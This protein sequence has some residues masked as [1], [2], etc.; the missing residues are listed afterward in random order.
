MG[1]SAPEG[2]KEEKSASRGNNAAANNIQINE[3]SW[4]QLLDDGFEE[5][6][7]GYANK[8]SVSRK[9]PAWIPTSFN[10]T[11]SEL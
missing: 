5:A 9:K 8:E 10:S 4:E 6:R 1:I 11:G 7:N 2:Y 3:A